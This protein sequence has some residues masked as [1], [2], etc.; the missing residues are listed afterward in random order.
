MS[1]T[2]IPE[3]TKRLLWVKSGGRCEYEGCNQLLYEDSLTKENMNKA[4]IAHIVGDSDN[5]PRGNKENSKVLSENID[6]LMLLCD[7]HHRLIDKE[8][9]NKH[10]EERLLLMKKEHEER[11]KIA[12]SITADK[13]STIVLYGANIG[14]L[15]P[16]LSYNIASNTIFPEY[17]PNNGNAIEIGLKNS[18]FK[19]DDNK[20]WFIEEENLISQYKS[21]IRDRIN[22]EEITHI[23]LFALAP[24]PLLVKLG[25]LFSDIYLVDVYQKHREPDIWKWLNSKTEIDYIVNSPSD[26]NKKPVLIFSLSAKI[27]SRIKN[28]FKDDASIWEVTIAE[29]NNDFLKTKNQ[30]KGFRITVRNLLN[31]IKQYTQ[32]EELM[33][34]MA[35][36]NA[37][38]IE[39]GRVWMPKA[40][41][42]LKLYDYNKNLREDVEAITIRNSIK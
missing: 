9:I 20:Y 8:G 24:M 32:K 19:D 23:S 39:L 13:C 29:P 22:K 6:N 2:S 5:G 40:D 4:Y 14:N 15:S 3:K 10:S 18:Y 33:I 37:C 26:V 34:F 21:K 28:R 16:I 30:L 1:K 17:Y 35:M 7:V 31:Q 25:T 27:T 38:A 12:T 41:M 42:S 11:I 36:P